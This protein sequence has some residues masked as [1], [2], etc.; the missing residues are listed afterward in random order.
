MRFIT[1]LVIVY[2]SFSKIDKIQLNKKNVTL[3]SN[4]QYWNLKISSEKSIEILLNTY[5][6]KVKD[7]KL[8]VIIK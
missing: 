7:K 6:S 4:K 5:M 3:N 8:L 1:L 2:R